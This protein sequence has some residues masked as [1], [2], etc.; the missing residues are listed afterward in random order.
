MYVLPPIQFLRSRD[1]IADN[2]RSF[3]ATS[4]S[5]ARSKS[6]PW[7]A[8]CFTAIVNVPAT[9]TLAVS[10]GVADAFCTLFP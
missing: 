7:K 4:G 8:P 9:W 5:K 2:A 3:S 6:D 10:A 1:T